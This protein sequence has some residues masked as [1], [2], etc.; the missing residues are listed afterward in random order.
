[1]PTAEEE[2]AQWTCTVDMLS[3]NPRFENG[4]YLEPS[5]ILGKN[6][7]YH[8]LTSLTLLD[9]ITSDLTKVRGLRTLMTTTHGDPQG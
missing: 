6:V 1:M 9:D 3:T 2:C 8:H 7:G 4:Y 5:M